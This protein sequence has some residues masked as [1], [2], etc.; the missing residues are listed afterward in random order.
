MPS[1]WTFARE[2]FPSAPLADGLYSIDRG[3]ETAPRRAATFLR[4]FETLRY[5]R[6]GSQQEG[7]KEMARWRRLYLLSFALFITQA[8]HAQQSTAVLDAAPV[9]PAIAAAKKVFISN[10]GEDNPTPELFSGGVDRCYREFYHQIQALHRYEL[11][12]SPTDADIVLEINQ[13]ATPDYIDI[14]YGA[15]VLRLRILDPKTRTVLWAF[16]ERPKRASLKHNTDRN[17]GI[18]IQKLVSDLRAVDS[19]MPEARP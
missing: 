17:L 5:Y 11:V 18:A 1:N 6:L 12:S 7:V 16:Y 9:P 3:F 10:A 13:T 15:A 19:N 2:S 4:M 8:T 14:R